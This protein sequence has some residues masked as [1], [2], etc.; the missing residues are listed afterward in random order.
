LR[1]FLYLDFGATKGVLEFSE[2]ELKGQLG[3]GSYGVVYKGEW[4]NQQVAGNH[5]NE[6]IFFSLNSEKNGQHSKRN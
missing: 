5:G 1:L 2:I 6:V 3:A 4:R